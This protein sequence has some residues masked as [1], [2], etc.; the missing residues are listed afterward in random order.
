MISL[1]AIEFNPPKQGTPRMTMAKHQK[2]QGT[3]DNQSRRGLYPQNP[4]LKNTKS[5]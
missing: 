3:A 5:S 4:D 2:Q 1:K